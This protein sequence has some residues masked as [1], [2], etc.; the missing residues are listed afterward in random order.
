[1]DF[2]AA[3]LESSAEGS[4]EFEKIKTAVEQAAPELK[5]HVRGVAIWTGYGFIA[6]LD[7]AVSI[8]GLAVDVS[9]FTKEVS[10]FLSIITQ[11]ASSSQYDVYSRVFAPLA[12]VPE[13]PVVSR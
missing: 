1:M 10:T 3:Q 7:K 2:P 9:F 11:P 8:E 12:G 6:E 4:A 13:D 5:G